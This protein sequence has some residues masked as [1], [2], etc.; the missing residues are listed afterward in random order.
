MDDSTEPTAPGLPMAWPMEGEE[1]DAARPAIDP[2]PTSL[3]AP[4]RPSL[5]EPTVPDLDARPRP[6]HA[7]WLH[8]IPPLPKPRPAPRTPLPS[9]EI[10]LAPRSRIPDAILWAAVAAA[11]FL[12]VGAVTLAAALLAA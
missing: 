8:V 3:V 1:A 7:T 9:E 6:A 12:L 2:Q 4:P 10:V 11:A 5:D